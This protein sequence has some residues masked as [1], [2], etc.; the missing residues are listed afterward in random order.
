MIKALL[1]AMLEPTDR[2]KKAEVTAD[3]TTRL[4][5]LEELKSYPFGAI[6]DYYCQ[7]NHVPV[8]EAWLTEVKQYEAEVLQKR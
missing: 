5:I 4:A 7:Q 6:W 8:R 3:F 2:L 1:R